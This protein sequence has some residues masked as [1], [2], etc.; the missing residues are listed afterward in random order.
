MMNNY[1]YEENTMK[2]FEISKDYL[3]TLDM[4]TDPDV[5]IS[6]ENIHHMLMAI[7]SE[8]REKAIQVAAFAKQMEAEA[9]A[10]KT[11][12]EN[13]SKRRKALMNRSQ[14]LKDYVKKE[15][16]TLGIKKIPCDWFILAIAKN[17]TA[18]D[19]VDS[20]AIPIEFLDITTEIKI[21][22]SAIKEAISSGKEIPGARLISSTRLSIR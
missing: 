9:D 14:W 12:E 10:I 3:N 6:P 5:N 11:A 19:I 13:M 20:D 18:I 17:P 8:F 21:N 2:L 16:D 1:Q 15:M 22:K 7:E 4:F